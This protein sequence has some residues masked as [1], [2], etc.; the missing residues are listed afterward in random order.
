MKRADPITMALGVYPVPRL[1]E[2]WGVPVRR[3]SDW[4]RAAGVPIVTA[5]KTTMQLVR[6]ADVERLFGSDAAPAEPHADT[7]LRLVT[8]EPADV[9]DVLRSVGLR[10]RVAR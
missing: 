2:L 4:L 10:R 1:A 7:A 6:L 5:P 3:L 9:D 8:D